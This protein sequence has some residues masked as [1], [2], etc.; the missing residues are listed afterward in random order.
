MTSPRIFS[1]VETWIFDLDNTLYPPSCGL[2]AQ[3]DERMMTFISERFSISPTEARTLQNS[4]SRQCGTGL[5]GLMTAHGVDP[6]EFMDFGH[7]R[8]RD[9]LS[10]D[11]ALREAI[12]ALPGRRYIPTNG[13][14]AHA[15]NCISA[16]G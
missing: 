14:R 5:R 9:S 7:N 1:H 15:E 6:D 2:F 11:A 4:Y 10:P 13:S 8:S 16:L 12:S 3:I